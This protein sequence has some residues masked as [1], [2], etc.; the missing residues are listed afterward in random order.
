MAPSPSEVSQLLV[1]WRNGDRGALDR[2]M[3]LVYDE[4]RRMA[5]R[6]MRGERENHTLQTSALVN[7]AYLRLADHKN[8]DWQNRAHFFGVAAQAMRR[9]LVDH[10]RT[11]NVRKSRST[12]LS[13]RSQPS[14]SGRRGSS[15]FG[16]SAGSRPR[17]PPR[18]SASRLPPSSATGRRP[19]RG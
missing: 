12:T 4:L 1:D 6:Y 8:M 15:S 2:L 14:T 7:E 19:G 17:R 11:R 16:T 9:V 18:S 10:A 3:P 5:G 13:G